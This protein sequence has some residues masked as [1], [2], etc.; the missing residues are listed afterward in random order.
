MSLVVL[1]LILALLFGIGGAVKGIIWFFLIALLLAL[2]GV[3]F[4][5]RSGL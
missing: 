5:T 3:G 4:G 2:L 1:F